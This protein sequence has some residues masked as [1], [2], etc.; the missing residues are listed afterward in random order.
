VEYQSLVPASDIAMSL[1]S[2]SRWRPYQ[3]LLAWGAYWVALLTVAIGPALPAIFRATRTPGNHGEINASAGDGGIHLIVKEM[4]QVTF[5]GSWHLL[6]TALWVAVPP[7]V[8]WVLW[9]RVRSGAIRSE[10]MRSP[11]R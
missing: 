10:P 1:F 4:G 7:L 6:T 11:S 5:S 8:L 9:L 2:L 3:L